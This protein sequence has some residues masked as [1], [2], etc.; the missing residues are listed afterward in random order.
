M[1]KEK[2]DRSKISDI[3]L[4]DMLEENMYGKKIVY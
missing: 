3:S 1:E 2:K 4:I